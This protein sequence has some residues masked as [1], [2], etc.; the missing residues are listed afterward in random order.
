M[1]P[2]TVDVLGVPL[3]LTDYERTHGLDGRHH[4]STQGKG[5]ICVAATH[6][7]VA[8][9]DDPELRAAVSAPRS[10]S[11]TASRSSGR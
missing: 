6:T 5:Y 11:L 7:V 8:C 3:A 9:Q 1:P 2:P 4:R 10:S